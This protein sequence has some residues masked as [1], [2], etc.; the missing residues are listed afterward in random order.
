LS[1]IGVYGTSHRPYRTI[2]GAQTT[3]GDGNE[4]SLFWTASRIDV[5]YRDADEYMCTHACHVYGFH[6]LRRG[7]ATLNVERMPAPVLQRKMRHRSFQT[8]LGYISLADKMKA[9]TDAVYVPEF[10]KTKASG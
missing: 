10:L 2:A 1:R 4:E 8:T 3:G 6:A 9:A 5:V 7:Y